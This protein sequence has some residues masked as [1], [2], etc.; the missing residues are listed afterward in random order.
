MIHKLVNTTPNPSAT[1]KSK[2]ELVGPP[3]V[4]P[5]LAPLAGAEDVAAG[6]PAAE[7]M[8]GVVAMLVRLEEVMVVGER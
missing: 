4:L 6:N 2:G 1:K 7:E 8:V 3:P 5:P